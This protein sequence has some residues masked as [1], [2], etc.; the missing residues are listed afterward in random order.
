MEKPMIFKDRAEAGRTLARLLLKYADRPDVIV[1]ALPRGG[2]PV[3]FEISRALNAPLDIFVVRKLGVPGHEELAMGAVATGGILYLN[4][5]VIQ[6]LHIDSTAISVV[7]AIEEEEI[8]RRERVYR[9]DLSPLHVQGKTII[10]VDDGLATGSTMRAAIAALRQRKPERIVVAVP[11]GALDVCKEIGQEADEAVCAAMP[12][13]FHA[14][15]QWYA[16][17]K[18]TTDEEVRDLLSRSSQSASVSIAV[19]G[20]TIQG[21]LARVANARGMVIFSHG[22]GSSRKSPRN[23]YVAGVLNQQGIA[24]LLVDLLTEEEEVRDNQ[25]LEHRFDID[26]LAERLVGATDWVVEHPVLSALPAGY[27]GASTGAAAAL[28]AAAERRKI[29]QAIVSRGGRP[30]LAGEAL[31]RVAA[32]T[33]LI[34]GELDQTVMKLNREAVREMSAETRIEVI[35]GATHLFEEVGAL[36]RVAVVASDWF[37]KKLVRKVA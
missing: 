17:F 27:F 8:K 5:D 2:V 14:V 26:L 16:E 31:R 18:Q 7:S 24:T 23:R 1:L 22:S 20:D 34:V 33:L 13:S 19:N 37:E 35:P 25:T 10:L 6:A 30:D 15:S 12:E 3:G 9:G 29:V 36:A 28:V 21:D 4:H 11:A 32:P